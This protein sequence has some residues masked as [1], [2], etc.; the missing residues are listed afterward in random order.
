M[1]KL[2]LISGLI[3]SLVTFVTAQDQNKPSVKGP[4]NHQNMSVE[5]RA[6]NN[7]NKAEKELALT[8][9]QKI[10]WEA[11]SIDRIKQNEPIKQKMQGSTTPEE[12]KNLREQMRANNQKFEQ[13]V[14]TFLTPDQKTKFEAMKK[15]KRGKGKGHG[16]REQKGD[17]APAP[18]EINKN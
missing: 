7:S 1:K 5:A 17:V 8:A 13:T 10:K 14:L 16:H 2:I 6:K 11:A 9:D 3:M 18:S 15:A 12:R 4:K